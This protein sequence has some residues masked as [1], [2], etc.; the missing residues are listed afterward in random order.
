MRS[1]S[2]VKY[3][4]LVAT[5]SSTSFEAQT[6]FEE[7]ETTTSTE[8]AE[9][10]TML[11]SLGTFRACYVVGLCS[12]G[13]FLFAYDTGIVGGV[14]TLAS[15]QRDFRYTKAEKTQ[16]NSNCVSILQGGAFFG[17]FLIWPVTSWLG[18]K[19]GIIV[20]SLVFCVGAIL[21]IIN[22]HSLGLFYAGRVIS[23]L[24]TG[25]ATVMVPMMAAEFAPKN[26]R[27]RL[28]ACFQL[29]FA[30]GVCVS[31]WVDYAASS[32]VSGTKSLQW[33]IPVALQLVPGGLLGLGMLLIKESPRWLAKKGRNEEAYKSL[34]WV[35]G[36]V[37]T[38]EV[39]AEFEEI[40]TGVQV[41][42]Q[43]SEG[44]T[45]KEL[46]LP[47]NR[48][49]IF[50]AVTI[51]LAAQ[52]SG[53]TSLAYFAPQFFALLGTGD[54]SIF[55]TGFFGLVKIAGVVTY[56][57]FFVDWLGRR[58][59]LMFGAGTMGILMLIVAIVIVKDPP[60]AKAGISSAGAAGIAMIYLEAF[61]FNFSWGPGE[62]EMLL[63]RI[64][65]NK[66]QDHGYT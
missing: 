16:V 64:A 54:K 41:E 43:A 62:H 12:I 25:G 37:E 50:L 34:I 2:A 4:R 35:R 19:W 36:G 30:T 6:D 40:L 60:N 42:I 14:L 1:S 48:Y 15:F 33:Q 31:Y 58:K 28:G 38:P 8:E 7:D 3:T 51:Q 13:S 24:G 45:Y 46:L 26:L 61:S 44:F 55:I 49:R 5:S 52:L 10:N 66:E 63:L 59:P 18:R 32:G 47:S 39:R 57:I 9:S 17:C 29:F 27:G 23:G 22:S 21:Q 53:N 65:A 56:I 11:P 20:S